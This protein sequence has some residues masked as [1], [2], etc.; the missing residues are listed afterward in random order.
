MT[1]AAMPPASSPFGVAKWEIEHFYTADLPEI[2]L[3]K[4]GTHGKSYL[5]S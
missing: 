4:M 1:D 5:G 3:K 2:V